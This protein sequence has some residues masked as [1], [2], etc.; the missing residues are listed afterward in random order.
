MKEEIK[1]GRFRIII[2]EIIIIKI[3]IFIIIFIFWVDG[4]GLEVYI[5]CCLVLVVMFFCMV[6]KD[7]SILICCLSFFVLFDLIGIDF[8]VE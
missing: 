7:C 2:D 8:M 4:C 5:F 1:E 3:L 6:N